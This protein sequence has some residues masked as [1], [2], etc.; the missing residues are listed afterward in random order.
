MATRDALIQIFGQFAGV[1]ITAEPQLSRVRQGFSDADVWRVAAGPLYC[2]RGWPLEHPPPERLKWMHGILGYARSRGLDY[3]PAPFT[4]RQGRTAVEYQD[5]RWA[6]TPWLP[7]VADFREHPSPL[8]LENAARALA[9]FH[10]A[11]RDLPPP[12]EG[13]PQ[14]AASLTPGLV[15]RRQR[16]TQLFGGVLLRIS[17]AL[18]TTRPAPRVTLGRELLERFLQLASPV[19]QDLGRYLAIRLPQQPCVR[20][21][22]A[23]HLLFSGDE[24]TGLIDYGAMRMDNVVGDL[25]RMLDSLLGPDRSRWKPA[26]TAYSAIRPLLR[27]ELAL[28]PAWHR[29]SVL[30]S[31]ATW[32]DWLFVERRQFN[33]QA[34][35]DRRLIELRQS[36]TELR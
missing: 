32:L 9:R 30:L 19:D 21:V 26:L 16:F 36:L 1:V 29:A 33:D 34:A 28:I 12:P 3:V 6:L 31:A 17:K 25:V 8:R 15:E 13:S 24:V 2:L 35:V 27:E 14:A 7:G 11:T 10:V 23:E 18:E 20:D 5:R 22:H 4:D